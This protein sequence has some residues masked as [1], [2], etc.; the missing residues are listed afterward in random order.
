MDQKKPFRPHMKSTLIL[1]YIF[2]NHRAAIF[3]NVSFCNDIIICASGRYDP[4]YPNAQRRHMF[5]DLSFPAA[6]WPGPRRPAEP[7]HE[8]LAYRSDSDDAAPSPNRRIFFFNDSR[9]YISDAMSGGRGLRRARRGSTRTEARARTAPAGTSVG[10]GGAPAG[11]GD[12]DIQAVTAV[13][14]WPAGGPAR[15]IPSLSLSQ[16]PGFDRH[17]D[18]DFSVKPHRRPLR[19]A[20]YRAS[21][22]STWTRAPG[23]C[24]N[25]LLFKTRPIQVLH[26]HGPAAPLGGRGRG[27]GGPTQSPSP[28][29]SAARRPRKS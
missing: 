6:G 23:P 22:K 24:D 25:F 28:G 16:W 20:A 10:A 8:S 9:D 29:L 3:Q 14:G 18:R 1:R 5:C 19:L 12:H 27:G 26:G 4:S 15:T 7:G 11:L 13:A 17:G 2:I 21:G